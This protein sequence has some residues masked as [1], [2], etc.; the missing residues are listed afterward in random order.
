MSW[1]PKGNR[2]LEFWSK[3]I[4]LLR[5][6]D[7]LAEELR[8]EIASHFEMELQDRLSQGQAPAEARISVARSF[9]NTSLI[10]ENAQ[11]EWRFQVLEDFLQ[12]LMY[13]ARSLRRTPAFSITAIL[14]LGLAIGGNTAVFSLIRGI[15]LRPLGYSAPESLVRISVD[16]PRQ[17]ITGAGFSQMRYEQM[18]AAAQSIQLGAFF[19]STEHMALTGAGEPEQLTVAR[20]S[21]N[22]LD[23]LGVQPLLG[24]N[25]LPEEDTTGG[26]RVVLI[27]ASLWHRRFSGDP[28]VI[29][30]TVILEAKPYSV[31]GV[32]PPHFSFPQGGLDAWVPRPSEMAAIAPQLWPRITVLVG[33]ARLRAAYTH[34]QAQRELDAINQ[35]YDAAHPGDTAPGS[36]LVAVALKE[37]TVGNVRQMLWVLL[38]AVAFVLMIACG[39]IAG[40]LLARANARSHEFAL[41][42][43]LGAGRSRLIRQL[44]TE[45]LLLHLAGGALG[46]LVAGWAIAAARRSSMVSLPRLDEVHL[47][48]SLL[49]FAFG[50]SLLTGLLFGL[51]PALHA[52][53]TDLARS[54]RERQETQGQGKRRAPIHPNSW[55]RLGTRNT[56]IVAQVALAVVLLTGSVLLMKSFI[57][58]RRVDPGIQPD[59]LLTMRID[60][61]STRYDTAEKRQAFFREV[62]QRMG[63]IP[64][65]RGVAAALTLPMT[66]RYSTAFEI[67]GQTFA[68]P[69]KRPQ[70]QLQSV[71]PDYFRTAGVRLRSG[72]FFTGRDNA[73]GAMP[74]VILNESCAR[75]LWAANPGAGDGIGLHVRIGGKP[76]PELEVV[77]IV[78]DVH[79]TGLA[80]N[81]S[82][83]IYVTDRFYPLQSAGL[84]IRADEDPARLTS[85]A[86]RTLLAIDPELPVS[87][88]RT[89]NQ[90]LESSIGQQRLLMILIGAFAFLALLLAVIGIYGVITNSVAQR[91][92]ELAIRQ[93]LGARPADILRLVAGQGLVLTLLGVA[94]GSLASMALTRL[95]EDLLFQVRPTDPISFVAVSLLFL[96]IGGAASCL[97]ARHAI[98]IDPMEALR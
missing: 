40:L 7:R 77:G 75:R 8:E 25:F 11:E 66:P 9:G 61:P 87:N 35:R 17:G 38:G 27:S 2:V 21:A 63:V 73:P 64:G 76:A 24:R 15:L 36:H 12:D 57:E 26:P 70:V 59:G 53:R 67:A 10:Q 42:T 88:V 69:E 78:A 85:E 32:L 34:E 60:L 55:L 6:R 96:V 3:L 29:G 5:R 18:K 50:I 91:T 97:P 80:R 39:N 68:N 41:R 22:C 30:R 48:A 82:P 47:D 49:F 37:Q 71:T 46:V 31:V 89:M 65:V 4:S 1:L 72:R 13:A 20:V 52:S 62:I 19:I 86:R 56:L 83:E 51:L 23:L 33:L 44:V 93:T 95:L 58:L 84:I 81:A 74:V 43:A 79:E 45:G 98:R 54:L 90:V 92:S 16:N 94:F 28:A 14:V